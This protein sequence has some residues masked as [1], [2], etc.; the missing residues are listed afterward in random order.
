MLGSKS[1]TS[2][3]LKLA[4]SAEY[5]R[6]NFGF[7]IL[8]KLLDLAKDLLSFDL[9]FESTISLV[10]ELLKYDNFLT[11]CNETNMTKKS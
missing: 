3:M 9:F 8:K 5:K 2:Y 7:S 4:T 10:I 1:K 11:N 6:E